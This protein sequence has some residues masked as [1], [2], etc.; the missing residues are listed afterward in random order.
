MHAEHYF[1]LRPYLRQAL[2]TLV[3]VALSVLVTVLV[4][5][6]LSPQHAHAQAN[7]GVVQATE[8]DLVGQDGTILARLQAGPH[9]NGNLT[10]YDTTGKRRAALGGDGTFEAFDPDGVTRRFV[11]GYVMDAQ[12]VPPVNGVL[13]DPNGTIG[14]LPSTSP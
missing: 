7:P 11:A 10:L 12:G 13:L 2:S 6:A 9:A 4:M 3:T 5:R 1:A 14:Y 8:F